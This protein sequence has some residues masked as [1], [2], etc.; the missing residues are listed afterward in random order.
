MGVNIDRIISF[1]FV[2]GSVLAG[3]AGILFA[4]KY[5]KVEPL[6]GLLPGIK[7]FIAAVF[8]GIGNIGGAVLGGLLIGLT[9]TFT[10]GY[11]SSQFSDLILYSILVVFM[12]FRSTGI[13]G[14]P[15][16]Q[17]V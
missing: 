17:K 13:R 3:T 14:A 16:L 7:A 2:L 10:V 5:P 8:G 12:L 11:L 15:V 6:M 4:I 9:E 1:T